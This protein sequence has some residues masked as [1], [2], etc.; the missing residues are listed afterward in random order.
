MKRF[1]FLL[2]LAQTSIAQ[3]EDGENAFENRKDLALIFAT[4][5]YDEWDDLDNPEINVGV[6]A[7]ELEQNYG[8]EID[9]VLNP[10]R[11]QIVSKLLGYQDKNFNEYDQLLIYF[12]SHGLVDKYTSKSY[13]I[14]KNSKINDPSGH[15]HL[16]HSHIKAMTDAI[17]SKHILLLLDAEYGPYDP[18][19][20]KVVVNEIEEPLPLLNIDFIKRKLRF[21][22]RTYFSTGEHPLLDKDSLINR[23]TFSEQFYKALRSNGAGDGILTKAELKSYLEILISDLKFGDFE[24]YEP[25][26]DFLFI[27]K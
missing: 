8:F 15:S 11:Q 10:T 16:S 26:S 5:K 12:A 1:V 21:K 3:I 17:P 19:P 18:K 27:A 6:I 7:Q 9:L 23:I 22:S 2:F 20:L 24:S 13:I 14:V 25:G 4:N